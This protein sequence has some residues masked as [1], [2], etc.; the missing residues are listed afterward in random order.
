MFKVI[1]SKPS[2][3]LVQLIV[4]RHLLETVSKYCKGSLI[5]IGCG[6]KPYK[7]LLAPYITDH[8]GLDH[9]HTLHEQ[10]NID[11]FGTAYNIPVGDNSFES[12]L[13]TAVLEHLEE[14]EQALKECHHLHC[15]VYLA[16]TRRT[17][18]LLPLQ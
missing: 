5:D 12:A 13:C 17:E 4:Q 1:N 18:G 3:I 8:I 7:E 11:L 9:T 6:T 16:F 15:T 2:N 10:S 14:P